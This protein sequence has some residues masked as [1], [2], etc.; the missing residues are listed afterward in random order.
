MANK[1][2]GPCVFNKFVYLYEN[3]LY[4]NSYDL[5]E[6]I[7]T[8]FTIDF[9]FQLTCQ[10][11]KGY[12]LTA[13]ETKTLIEYSLKIKSKN[14]AAKLY[15]ELKKISFNYVYHDFYKNEYK[16]EYNLK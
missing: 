7:K 10:S 3:K 6:V 14:E 12:A 15:N 11:L 5:F 4:N 13:N 2:L 8:K 16:K 1:G 9:T